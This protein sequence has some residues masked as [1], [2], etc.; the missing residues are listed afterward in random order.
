[1]LDTHDTTP[2]STTTQCSFHLEERTEPVTLVVQPNPSNSIDAE[3][4]FGRPQVYLTPQQIARVLIARAKL[5]DT[6]AERAAERI[7]RDSVDR[8]LPR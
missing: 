3:Y 6:R 2:Y 4:R 5:G 8:S 7:T 1:M